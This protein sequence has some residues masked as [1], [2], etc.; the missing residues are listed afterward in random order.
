MGG[1]V[2]LTNELIFTYLFHLF[3]S[4]VTT[5]ERLYFSYKLES[6]TVPIEFYSLFFFSF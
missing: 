6:V 4:F 1:G 5:M 2:N 3:K